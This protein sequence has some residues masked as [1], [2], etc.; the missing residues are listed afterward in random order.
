MAAVPATRWKTVQRPCRFSGGAKGM[1]SIAIA[2]AINQNILLFEFKRRILI[3]PLCDIQLGAN[4]SLWATQWKNIIRLRLLWDWKSSCFV[5]CVMKQRVRHYWN[6]RTA[7]KW[8]SSLTDSHVP[9]RRAEH[10]CSKANNHKRLI[11]RPRNT[12]SVDRPTW[13]AWL[14]LLLAKCACD[15]SVPRLCHSGSRWLR[16]IIAT[17]KNQHG[18]FVCVPEV[19][20]AKVKATGHRHEYTERR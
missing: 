16:R 9:D 20:R 5:N 18:S 8:H 17:T 19:R 10:A 2:I 6:Q 15:V 12:A 4:G 7:I 3:R 13:F 14:A 11:G 1:R